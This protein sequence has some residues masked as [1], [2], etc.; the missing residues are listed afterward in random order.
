MT[1]EIQKAVTLANNG[2]WDEAHQI[3]QKLHDRTAFWLHANLHREE[4]DNNNAQY[5][6]TRADQPFSTESLQVER[7]HILASLA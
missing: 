3:V 2:N 4:G 6:Y 7:Q 5:W 1:T